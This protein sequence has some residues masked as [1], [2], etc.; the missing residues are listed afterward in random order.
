ML[1][2]TSVQFNTTINAGH[3]PTAY[4]KVTRGDGKVLGFTTIKP[5]DWLL[6]SGSNYTATASVLAADIAAPGSTTY[7]LLIGGDADADAVSSTTNSITAIAPGLN[8]WYW[9]K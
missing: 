5:T 4:I 8:A 6:V 3:F 1:I 2:A 7:T 9:K